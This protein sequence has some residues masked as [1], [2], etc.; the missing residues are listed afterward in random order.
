MRALYDSK[1]GGVV[2][3]HLPPEYWR[4]LYATAVKPSPPTSNCRSCGAPAEVGKGTCTYC[5][6]PHA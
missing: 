3:T 4:T 1:P 5:G 2:F 6:T